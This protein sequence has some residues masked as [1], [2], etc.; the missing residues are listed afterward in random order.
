MGSQ[1]S[2]PTMGVTVGANPGLLSL[3]VSW[4]G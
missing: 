2:S 4:W 1:G 3:V